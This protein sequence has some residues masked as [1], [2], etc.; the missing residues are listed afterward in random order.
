[1]MADFDIN[2]IIAF[3]TNAACLMVQGDENKAQQA[4][5]ETLD[6][7]VG[8]LGSLQ[9]EANEM[10]LEEMMM[11]AVDDEA[12]HQQTLRFLSVQQLQKHGEEDSPSRT[13]QGGVLE[14]FRKVVH[15]HC[16]TPPVEAEGIPWNSQ[17]ELAVSVLY[18]AGLFFHMKAVNIGKEVF[19]QKS[20]KYYTVA[21]EMITLWRYHESDM[22]LLLAIAILNNLAHAHFMLGNMSHS[23]EIFQ[24]V[25]NVFLV[26]MT[27]PNAQVQAWDADVVDF[28]ILTLS[29]A[30]PNSFAIA[31]AA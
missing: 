22:N 9:E 16:P 8:L 6:A 2:E 7:L 15:V 18:N 27:S 11:M 3:N 23:F 19:L 1:M 25:K 30:S 13:P 10:D 24:E 21:Y 29:V 26:A 28:A 31:S 5:R 14:L 17:I 4:L 20:I 12:S